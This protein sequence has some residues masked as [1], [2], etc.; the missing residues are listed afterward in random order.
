MP[1]SNVIGPN[2]PDFIPMVSGST[3]AGF[4]SVYWNND[5]PVASFE[6]QPPDQP[7]VGPDLRTLVGY[8]GPGGGCVPVK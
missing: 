7:V 8:S 3:V 6:G 4:V 2:G 1:E 5:A